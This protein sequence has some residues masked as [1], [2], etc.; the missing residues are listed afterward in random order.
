LLSQNIGVKIVVCDVHCSG[1]CVV[2]GAGK[3]DA[4]CMSD[5]TFNA[6]EYVCSPGMLCLIPSRVDS[7]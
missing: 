4:T 2:Q 1:G 3:C 6:T 7:W 5:Y